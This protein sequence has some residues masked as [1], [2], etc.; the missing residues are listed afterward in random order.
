MYRGHASRIS[1]TYRAEQDR[2]RRQDG[3]GEEQRDELGRTSRVRPKDVVNGLTLAIPERLRGTR[4]CRIH[5][6]P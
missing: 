1:S 6:R 2:E 5:I 4:R 3:H